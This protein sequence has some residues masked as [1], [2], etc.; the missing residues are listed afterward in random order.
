MQWGKNSRLA[1]EVTGKIANWFTA[2]PEGSPPRQ[3]RREG[4]REGSPDEF[5]ITQADDAPFGKTQTEWMKNCLGDTL[6]TFANH[7]EQRITAAEGTA[8]EAKKIAEDT[9]NEVI[10]IKK[11]LGEMKNDKKM[12]VEPEAMEEIWKK[13]NEINTKADKAAAAP[14]V[15]RSL[16]PI[17]DPDLDPTMTRLGNLGWDTK[18]EFLMERGTETMKE[19][20]F[21]MG[22]GMM[23]MEAAVSWKGTG[24]AVEIKF[25]TEA[26][27]K[28]AATRIRGLE[29]KFISNK[30]VWLAVKRTTAQNKAART[31]YRLSDVVSDIEAQRTDQLEVQKHVG[32]RQVKIQGT[33]AF[34]TYQGH[35]RAS[36]Y[37]LSRYSREDIEIAIGYAMAE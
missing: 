10:E 16:A 25:D 7:V 11:A 8:Q 27:M 4:A 24:S 18:A 5:M 20:G 22:I 34:Y 29:K 36:A 12:D 2:R 1:E 37:A 15:P 26:H 32:A 30:I 31:I 14:Q 3:K 13:I 21:E 23:K 17:I 33:L 19:I 6:G 28:E 9:Q 35:V